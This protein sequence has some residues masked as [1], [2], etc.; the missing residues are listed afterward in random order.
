[1]AETNPPTPDTTTP[2]V[3]AADKR[4]P[5][6]PKGDGSGSKSGGRPPRPPRGAKAD[7]AAEPAIEVVAR[8]KGKREGD[9]ITISAPGGERNYEIVAVRYDA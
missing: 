7:A 8:G 1:M 3:A 9:P 4:A 6:P 5:R 2:A